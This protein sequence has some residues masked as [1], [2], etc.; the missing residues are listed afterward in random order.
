MRGSK[1][2]S[3]RLEDQSLERLQRHCAQLGCDVSQVVRQALQMFWASEPVATA[4]SR[5]RRVSPPGDILTLIP[6]YLNWGNGGLRKHRNQLFLEL[7]AASFT[8]K[9]HFPRT[10]GMIEGYEGLLQLCEFFGVD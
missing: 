5:Q 1:R 3:V 9:K 10:K 8:C 6:R 7:L 4:G 2:I